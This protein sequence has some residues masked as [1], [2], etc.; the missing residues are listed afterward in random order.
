MPG[1]DDNPWS[2]TIDW[3]DGSSDDGSTGSQSAPI[4]GSHIYLDPDDYQVTITITDKDGGSGEY[5][6]TISAEGLRTD[7]DI[8]P[9]SWPNSL[10][11]NGNGSV[12]VGIF[13]STEFNVHDIDKSTVRCGLTGLEAVPVHKGYCGHVEDLNGDGIDDMVFHFREGELGIPVDTEGNEEL[14][15]LIA[16]QLDN[17]IYFEGTDIVRITPNDESSRGKGGKGPK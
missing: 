15:L 1:E 9:G 13:G 7:I 2:W 14:I 17:G 16:G 4:T 5:Q 11:L 6:L 12:P 10:N 3:G 8:K